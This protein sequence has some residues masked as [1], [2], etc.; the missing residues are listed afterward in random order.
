MSGRGGTPDGNGHSSQEPGMDDTVSIGTAALI[1]S[2][3]AELSSMRQVIEQQQV[4]ISQLTSSQATGS[5]SA[6]THPSGTQTLQSPAARVP[7]ITPY[8]GKRGQQTSTSVKSFIYNVRKVGQLSN[9][10]EASMLRYAECYLQ[11]RAATWMMGLEEASQ[12]PTTVSEMQSAMIKEFVPPDE[13][14]QA[15]TRLMKIKMMKSADAYISAFRDL[16]DV[17]KTPLSEAYMYFFNG[18]PDALKEEFQKKY[19][20][21]EP[22]S[23]QD[24]Y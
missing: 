2:L 23:L 20:T 22:A 3:Q 10:D 8:S 1:Q 21:S 6:P 5:H 11:D 9:M 16:V 19:P 7:Q 18:L 14:A 17:C 13:K 4:Q 12:L 24:V 15:K